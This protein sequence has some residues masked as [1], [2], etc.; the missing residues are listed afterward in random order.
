M[1]RIFPIKVLN[2]LG[3]SI[4][5]AKVYLTLSTYGP[6]KTAAIAKQSNVARQ[7]VYRTLNQ[8]YEIGI[9]EKIILPTAH[10][11]ALPI[12]EGTK[13]LLDRR[14]AGLNKVKK[15]RELLLASLKNKDRSEGLKP[16]NNYFVML[17]KKTTVK[18]IRQSITEVKDLIEAVV[19]WEQFAYIKNT[20][21]EELEQLCQKQVKIRIIVKNENKAI[22]DYGGF[23]KGYPTFQIRS[24]DSCPPTTFA[25]Y[26]NT[27]IF[28]IGDTTDHLTKSEALWTNNSNLVDLAKENFEH[29]WLTAKEETLNEDA[30]WLSIKK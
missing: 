7:D 28:V 22:E 24:I 11:K 1:W 3:L 14:I 21:S 27:A 19:T 6:L 15:E 29:L 23:F 13:L 9:V 5:Q 20:F 8:L 10:F 12:D 26:D 4:T 30:G 17:P 16:E 25:V 18:K 2:S